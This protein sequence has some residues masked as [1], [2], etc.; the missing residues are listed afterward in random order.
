MKDNK[1]KILEEFKQLKGQFVIVSF[2]NIERLVAIGE[3]DEDY[4]W[5]TYDG[6]EFKWTSCAIS[7]MP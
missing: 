2:N 6:K 7:I 3:D 1:E 4:Y 5:I